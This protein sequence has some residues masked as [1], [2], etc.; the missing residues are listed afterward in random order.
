DHNH[1]LDSDPALN[2]DPNHDPDH[3][4]NPDHDPDPLRHRQCLVYIH[5]LQ[6]K[7]HRPAFPRDPPPQRGG[8]T[9]EPP[10]SWRVGGNLRWARTGLV[11]PP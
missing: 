10:C 5:F 8:P 2:H 1:D 3:D 11:A 9:F 7:E 6:K 4:P